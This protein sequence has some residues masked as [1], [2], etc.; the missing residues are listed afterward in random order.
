MLESKLS[1]LHQ[2]SSVHFN[3]DPKLCGTLNSTEL[4]EIWSPSL[5]FGQMTLLDV[6]R[7]P[8]RASTVTTIS[9]PNSELNSLQTTPRLGGG[10]HF[11]FNY[12]PTASL[13]ADTASMMSERPRSASMSSHLTSGRSSPIKQP[14][15]CA[16][17]PK[18]FKEKLSNVFRRHS[19]NTEVREDFTNISV[20]EFEVSLKREEFTQSE[21]LPS[22]NQ[23]DQ[24]LRSCQNATQVQA[25]HPIPLERENSSCSLSLESSSDSQEKLSLSL[26]TTTLNQVQVDSN[27]ASSYPNVDSTVLLASEKLEVI[28]NSQE[29]PGST[30]VERNTSHHRP[31][32]VTIASVD[33][34]TTVDTLTPVDSVL[35]PVMMSRSV[36]KDKRECSTFTVGHSP[37]SA[38]DMYIEN[39]HLLHRRS[40][41][42]IP[43]TE[44]EG[45]DWDHYGTCP[46]TDELSLMHNLMVMVHSQLLFERYQCQQHAKRNRRLM[47]KARNANKLENEIVTL[48]SL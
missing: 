8:S 22:Q 19:D 20:S 38:L 40:L 44:L 7:N 29:P 45:I 31:S 6:P 1:P 39:G 18:S 15:S 36:L 35:S 47:T 26:P 10:H 21:S 13:E 43:L 41:K 28:A 48:V 27:K 30:S 24:L 11:V 14:S 25:T 37:L 34:V 42:E 2:Q 3:F 17:T 9:S 4:A 23:N 33:S 5:S 46:H 12:S 32:F 16:N